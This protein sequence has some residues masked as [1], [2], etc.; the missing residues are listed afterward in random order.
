MSPEEYQ[1]AIENIKANRDSLLTNLFINLYSKLQESTLSED[2]QE[3]LVLLYQ[4]SISSYLDYEDNQIELFRPTSWVEEPPIIDT[5]YFLYP[6]NL[7]TILSDHPLIEIYN[8]IIV[9]APTEAQMPESRFHKLCD[10]LVEGQRNIAIELEKKIISTNNPELLHNWRS[11]IE[12]LYQQERVTIEEFHSLMSAEQVQD[13][14]YRISQYQ[15]IALHYRNSREALYEQLMEAHTIFEISQLQITDPPAVDLSHSSF[16]SENHNS[17]SSAG[18]TEENSFSHHDTVNPN[19][20]FEFGTLGSIWKQGSNPSS[21]LFSD[22][23]D[24]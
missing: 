2:E 21:S 13:Y 11:E 12:R 18:A 23:T 17:S 24:L 3:G 1:I 16:V 8:N 4:A 6:T 5:L 20:L 7:E 10:L 14:N 19:L 22:K 9:T 15:S